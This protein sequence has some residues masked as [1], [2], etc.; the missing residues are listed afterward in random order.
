MGV[1]GTVA[2]VGVDVGDMV[3]LEEA[4]QNSSDADSSFSYKV[5]EN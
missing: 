2:I 1:P 4:G 5:D 3:S